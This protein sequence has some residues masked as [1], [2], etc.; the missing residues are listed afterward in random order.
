[1]ANFTARDEPPADYCRQ[2]VG[3]ADVYVGIVGFRYGS[4]VADD[5]GRSYTE[6]EYDAAGE[7][8]LPRLVF[9]L[10]DEAVLPLPGK[11][12]SDPEYGHRQAR[13][14]ER[15]RTAG[16][17]VA[18]VSSPDRLETLVF[19]ALTD[20]RR[21]ATGITSVDGSAYLEQV[22]R[23]A[24]DKLHGRDVELTALAEFCTGPDPV[25]YAWWQAPAW[26]GKS[27]LLSW[28][29]LH[30]PEGIPVVS[31]FITAR[32]KAQDDRAAFIDAVTEQLAVLLRRPT[33]GYLAEAARE[34]HLLAWLAEAANTGR[35][36]VLVVDGLDEDRGVTAGPDAY[37]IAALLPARPPP[38]LRV[39]VAGRPDPP[40]P[41][42]VPDDHPLRNP[43][44]VRVLASS[45]AAV[46]VRSDMQRELTRLLHGDQA[47]QDLLG[48][49]T[50]AG[51][52]LSARD[53]AEL[54][55]IEEHGI[56]ETLH[57]MA[58]RT[59]ATRRGHWQPSITS[60]VYVL[61]HEELQARRGR[62][63][64]A[65]STRALPGAAAWLGAEVPYA[66]LA[67]WDPGVPA[68]WLFPAASGSR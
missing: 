23:I 14:R 65:G 26:A 51:G 20:L 19:Q 42:D 38:G 8:G 52:G 28:F 60:P 68:A 49:I 24:P 2:Q 67:H 62:C 10:D 37:S 56:E 13:F 59:F 18:M 41:D 36:L 45:P 61:G 21:Q 12:L 27:A 63:S 50:A 53:L 34:H 25:Q 47:Q 46:V 30:P 5:L 64:G 32:Y 6:L 48:L 22:R 33:P 4:P 11:F 31:F 29:V 55:G 35:G 17:T 66:R 15:V 9:V 44:I 3:R 58:R 39:I 1:M 7:L 16:P 57:T 54:T 40:V 43:D